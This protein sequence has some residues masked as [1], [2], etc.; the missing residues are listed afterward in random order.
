VRCVAAPIDHFL[1]LGC[2][3]RVYSWNKNGHGQL[4]HGDKLDRPSPTLVEGLEDVREVSAGT[5]RGLAVMQPGHVFRWGDALEIKGGG[6]LVPIIVDGF[7]GVRVRRI[8]ARGEL[9]PS[10]RP[11]SSF[12]GVR[13]R[14]GLWV[15]ATRKTSPRPSA[16]RR[17]GAWE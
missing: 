15:M 12:R 9:S 10:A 3:G 4:G 14:T 1:A 5:W 13:A 6:S 8:V 11:E 7:G 17:C 16:L 2:D